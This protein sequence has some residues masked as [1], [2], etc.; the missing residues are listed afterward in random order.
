MDHDHAQ[1]FGKQDY[2]K[3]IADCTRETLRKVSRENF[4]ELPI[5]RQIFQIFPLSTICATL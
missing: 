3:S 4:D 1:N 2:D 5:I